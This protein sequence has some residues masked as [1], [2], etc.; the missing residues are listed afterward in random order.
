[1]NNPHVLVDINEASAIVLKF[2]GTDR[3]YDVVS[4]LENN[5]K[6]GFNA[7]LSFAICLAMAECKTFLYHVEEQPKKQT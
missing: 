3:Y 4:S 1:M 2:I 5:A 6:A 7:G